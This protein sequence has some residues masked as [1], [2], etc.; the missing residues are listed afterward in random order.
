MFR[1]VSW[2]WLY[3]APT[4]TIKNQRV[5]KYLLELVLSLISAEQGR[6]TISS[7]AGC[8]FFLLVMCCTDDSHWKGRNICPQLHLL[9]FFR[10][11]HWR[12]DLRV[13]YQPFRTLLYLYTSSVADKSFQILPPYHCILYTIFTKLSLLFM[14]ALISNLFNR[15]QNQFINAVR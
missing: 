7:Q 8:S 13:V 4:S 11:I 10:L 14:W 3:Q 5:N 1:K 2:F 6:W 12:V 9:I 15:S